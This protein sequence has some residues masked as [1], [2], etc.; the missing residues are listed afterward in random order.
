M[1]KSDLFQSR[2]QNPINGSS[3]ETGPPLRS[4]TK[5]TSL[6]LDPG[7]LSRDLLYRVLR[8]PQ[9]A[10]EKKNY[11]HVFHSLVSPFLKIDSLARLPPES[12]H[13]IT[14]NDV[15]CSVRSANTARRWLGHY[16]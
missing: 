10:G 7:G 3:L 14:Y 4:Y 6:S 13:Q 11:E 1:S 16:R 5:A 15:R 12:R 9:R 8:R 2:F